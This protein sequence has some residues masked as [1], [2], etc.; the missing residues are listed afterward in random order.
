MTNWVQIRKEYEENDITLKA[1]ADKYGIS[2]STIRSRKNREDWQRSG[3]TQRNATDRKGGQRGNA[4]AK[5]NKGGGAPKDNK[6][7]VSHGLF[8]N[9]LPEEMLE[10]MT[11]LNEMTPADMIWQNILI[12]YTAIVRSQ[13][14]MFVRNESDDI[15][16]ITSVKMNPSYTD[17]K[18]NPVKIE[19]SREWHLAYERHEKFLSAQSRAVTTLSNLIKQFVALSDEA[20]ERRLNLEIMQAKLNEMTPS[21]SQ[22]DSLAKY[23]RTLRQAYGGETD[24]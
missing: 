4:N 20:D 3:A 15:N 22:E 7:A 13:K 6:N 14:I 9:Y 17:E 11:E 21:E 10:I 2:P 19:E 18:G 16:N 5:G 12:Q 8:A 1:L 24:D 23:M